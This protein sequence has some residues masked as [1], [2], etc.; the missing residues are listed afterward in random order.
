MRLPQ[1]ARAESG[2]SRDDRSLSVVLPTAVPP[3]RH[4]PPIPMDEPRSRLAAALA[5]R[6]RFERE[7][8]QGGMATVYLA[9]DLRHHR[10]V[11][12]KLMRPEL[13]AA[14]GAERF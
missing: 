6:Y 5:D 10:Q 4:I 2:D 7:L 9:Q 11:A 1:R 14:I 12:I 3:S 13:S 8:G